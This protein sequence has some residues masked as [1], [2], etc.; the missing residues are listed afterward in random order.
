MDVVLTTHVDDFLWACTESGHAIV[1]RLLTKFEVGRKEKGSIRFCG[2]QFD[3][4]GRDNLLDVADNNQEDHIRGNRQP[5]ESC[6]SCYQ[7]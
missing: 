5:Q 4:S 7:G 2:K 1:D 3:V 6:G